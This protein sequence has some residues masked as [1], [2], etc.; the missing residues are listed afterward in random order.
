MNIHPTSYSISQN[1][2]EKM[3]RH[4]S[5]VI[6]FT[7]LSGSG[8][9]SIAQELE[10][11][12]F[13]KNIHCFPLDGDNIRTGLNSDLDFSDQDRSENIRR[14]S[15]VAKLLIQSGQVVLAS[16]IS[17]FEKDRLEAKRIIREHSFFEV[18]VDTP[19]E[20]CKKRDPKGLYHKVEKGEIKNFTGINSPYETPKNPDLIL[21]T[22]NKTIQECTTELLEKILPLIELE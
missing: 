1:E 8:K 9:S 7:G 2:R 21:S 4:K 20:L 6:W 5:I 12:L 19:L 17:P 15:E 18:F 22:E 11:L 3:N 14:I 16:F 10:R 13:Q